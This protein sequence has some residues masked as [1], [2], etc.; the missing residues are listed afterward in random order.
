MTRHQ[1][2]DRLH[3]AIS[4]MSDEELENLVRDLEE[5]KAMETQA[6]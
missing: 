1:L 6:E 4:C 5:L 2:L 3:D